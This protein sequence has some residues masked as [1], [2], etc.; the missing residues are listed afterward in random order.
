MKDKIKA[1]F[2]SRITWGFIGTLAGTFG[3]DQAVNI[4]NALGS[5]VMAIL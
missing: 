3:G 2:D 5:F 1:V 4:A